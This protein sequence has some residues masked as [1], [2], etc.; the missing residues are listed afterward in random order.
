MVL[1]GIISYLMQGLT[2]TPVKV[3]CFV[4]DSLYLLEFGTG[5]AK[6]GTFFLHELDLNKEVV[7]PGI[8]SKDTVSVE[9]AAGVRMKPI[10]VIM[11]MRKRH[12]N[13]D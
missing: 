12:M 2:S 5:M 1:S 6:F 13:D 11:N 9:F 7:L 4:R 3:E 10:K 8:R